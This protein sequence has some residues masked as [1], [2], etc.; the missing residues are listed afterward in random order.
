MQSF[1][2]S[3]SPPGPP[4]AVGIHIALSAEAMFERIHLATVI[5]A[6]VLFGIYLLLAGK[7]EFLEL[8]A[9]AASAVLAIIGSE[10]VKAQNLPRFHPRVRWLARS[11]RV[12]ISF[13]T[14]SAIIFRFLFRSASRQLKGGGQFRE[15]PFEAGSRDRRSAARKVLAV[16]YLSL[17]PSSIVVLIDQENKSMLLHLLGTSAVPGLVGDW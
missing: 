6:L 4:F 14:G 10:F 1:T 13:F 15:V 17:G 16:I 2:F 12:P 5:R 8:I 7:F 9:G 3:C 11:W